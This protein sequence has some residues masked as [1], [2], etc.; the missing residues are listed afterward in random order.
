MQESAATLRNALLSAGLIA[1]AVLTYWPS[2][3]A[4]WEFWAN[5]NTAGAHGFLVAPLSAWLLF[6]VRYRLATVQVRPSRLACGLLLVCSIGWLI[7]WRAGIQELHILL[8]P[9][10]MGLSVFAALGW[11]AAL[12]VAFPIGYLYF[13]VPAW[14]LF[15]GP[16]QA[17]TVEA[18]RVLAPL[19]GVPAH[20][21]GN[22]V[23]VPGGEIE[24]A[25]G[26]SGQAFL[27]VGLAVAAL[28][29]E[30]ESASLRRRILL[31]GAMGSLAVISNWIRVL[32]IVEAG[33]STH[34]RHVLV[35]RGHFTFGWVL[36][37]TVM[38]AFVWLSARQ[39]ATAA[40]AANFQS[41]AMF[42]ARMPTYIVSVIALV[43]MPLIVYTIVTR[44]DVSAKPLAFHAPV[45]RGEWR[46]PV[47]TG[48]G[49]WQ[50]EF[51]G[52]HSQ[53]YVAYQGPAGH[54]V[55]MVAIGYSSQ[56]Q[57]RELVNEENSLFGAN[58]PAAAAEAKVTL[59]GVSYNELVAADD[60]GHRLLAWSVYDI[61]GRE[62]ATPLLSQ[63]WYGVRSLSGAPYSVQ[64][65]FRTACDVSC[66]SARAT[67]SSFLQAMRADCFASVSR[68]PR[69]SPTLRPL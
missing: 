20:I 32:T 6:R 51:V 52:P 54:N 30:L 41:G 35:T 7:F 50:P 69:S 40:R 68:A 5:P 37:S 2:T 23:F 39:K 29:G 24:V 64:F 33:Y 46:G 47:S 56:A 65:A 48:S 49:A 25:P 61:G 8:L 43:A 59:D 38:V 15:V 34:M 42:G 44:L 55:E 31:L 14:G 62:F 13:A 60:R 28:L 18:V 27:A 4:L 26:C 21:Q 19:I 66:D 57:G 67:L 9:V 11:E 10:L 1:L 45:G 16:L 22:L 58:A 53:W 3:T 36:F 17:L 12:I 63:L